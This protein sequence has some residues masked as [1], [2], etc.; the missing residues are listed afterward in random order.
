VVALNPRNGEVLA[1]VSSPR[2][3]PNKFVGGISAAEWAALA[4]DPDNPLMNRATQAQLAPGSIFKPIVGWAAL[5]TGAVDA[6]FQVFCGGGASFFGRYFRCHRAGGHGW[7][8]MEQALIKS[9]DVFFY[10]LGKELGIDRIAQYSEAAGL[11]AKTGVDLPHEEEGVVPSSKWKVR[12]FRDR[13]WPGETISVA[14]GQGALT[15]TPIQAAHAIG[16]LAMGGVW[17]KPHLLPYDEM[18]E[19]QPGFEPAE[20]RRA[21]IDPRH[22]D[23]ILQGLWGVVNAGGTGARA[24]IPGV[25]VC[26][27]T[28]SAQRVSRAFAQNSD[29]PRLLD[30][31]WFV[32]FAPCREPEIVVTA[33][34]EN[35]EH[36]AL[37]GPIVRDVIKAYFDK[38]ARLEWNRRQRQ[39]EPAAP[40]PAPA[41]RPSLAA[42]EE[43][44]P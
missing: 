27:K 35:G 5:D 30:D 21:H 16:G 32:G 33:L 3:D 7:V 9:C 42:A 2:F 38:K 6:N 40:A 11:G 18:Q 41:Q 39:G 24:M 8:D 28:G 29:D 19:L 26:G 4:D 22:L 23:L 10:T 36:G 13:W 25:E 15:L 37:A 31:G 34:F 20:P 1:L 43:T 12:L 14:I 44:L 17:H